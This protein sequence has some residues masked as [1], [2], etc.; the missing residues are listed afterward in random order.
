LDIKQINSASTINASIPVNSITLFGYTSPGSRVELTSP[1]VYAVT[2]SE[3]DGY[4]IFDH[5]VLPRHSQDLCLTSIDESNRINNPVCIPEPPPIN[6]FTKIGPIILSPSISLDLKNN[7]SSGQSIPNSIIEIYFYQQSSPISAIKT[8]R[9]FA[10]PIFETTS[11]SKGNYTLNIP[12]TSATNYRVFATTKYLDT[13]SPKSNTLL[14]HPNYT[15]SL[16][17]FLIPLLLI[18]VSLIF[19][20]KK[21][22]QRFLPAIFY[23]KIIAIP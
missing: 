22:H 2:Y 1:K 15:I 8:V 6:S 11:D 7:Y 4:F 20:F 12:D 21:T 16:I 3:N 9:A 10:L 17:Y 13:N 5:V 18:V 14:Y 19:I 23:N